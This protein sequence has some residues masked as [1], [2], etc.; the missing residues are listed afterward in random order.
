[1][2]NI[3]RAIRKSEDAVDVKKNFEATYSGRIGLFLVGLT[4][5]GMPSYLPGSMLLPSSFYKVSP[6][7]R[8]D[9]VTYDNGGG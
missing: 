5:S 2:L 7:I 1:M 8:C 9:E 6:D 3:F 4:N